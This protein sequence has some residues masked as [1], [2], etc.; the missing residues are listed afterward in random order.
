MQCF[1]CY[2]N[3]SKCNAVSAAVSRLII[4]A[5]TIACFQNQ[6]T[7]KMYSVTRR[8]NNVYDTQIAWELRSVLFCDFSFSNIET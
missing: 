7:R 4:Y 8:K 5:E 2:D 6:Q 1:K 3:Q